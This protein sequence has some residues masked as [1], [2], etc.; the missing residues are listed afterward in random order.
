MARLA[1]TL[2]AP[3]VTPGLLKE[4]Y[5]R[6]TP[7]ASS[8]DWSIFLK[9]YTRIW[10]FVAKCSVIYLGKIPRMHFLQE[11]QQGPKNQVPQKY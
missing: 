10:D 11:L 6:V 2:A 9:N 5:T 4:N 3:Q 7:S 8:P 1:F